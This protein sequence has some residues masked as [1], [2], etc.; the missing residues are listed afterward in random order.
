MLW[1]ID[2]LHETVDVEIVIHNFLYIWFS[3]EVTVLFPVTKCG[4]GGMVDT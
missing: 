4:D 3:L 2:G 1:N